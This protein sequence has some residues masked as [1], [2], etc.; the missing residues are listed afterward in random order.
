L[1]EG[2][3]LCL[4][5]LDEEDGSFHEE[6]FEGHHGF[7]RSALVSELGAAGFTDV[8][9]HDCYEIVRED[10]TYPIFLAT[11]RRGHSAGSS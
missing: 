7:K 4:V 2:G 8:T 9:F 11:C 1:E 6:P 5:D 3:H 10:V